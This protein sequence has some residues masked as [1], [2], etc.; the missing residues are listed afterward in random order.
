MVLGTLSCYP[1]SMSVLFQV[2]PQY[3]AL[4]G[5]LQVVNWIML[6]G[7]LT[8]SYFCK[9][10][11]ECSSGNFLPKLLSY[12]VTSKVL[13]LS[14]T[15][16]IQSFDRKR[17]AHTSSPLLEHLSAAPAQMWFTAMHFTIW[18][19]LSNV[20]TSASYLHIY[21]LSSVHRALWTL[22]PK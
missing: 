5:E 20:S 7:Y 11:G 22:L 9:E 2:A 4:E 14:P 21:P 15:N 1:S 8:F 13:S 19:L 16:L 6:L 18:G 3:C 10:L 12:K 17:A